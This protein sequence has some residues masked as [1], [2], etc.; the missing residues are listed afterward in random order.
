MTCQNSNQC[1]NQTGKASKN[2]M[3]EHLALWHVICD[4]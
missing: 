4:R 1:M 3:I 2:K